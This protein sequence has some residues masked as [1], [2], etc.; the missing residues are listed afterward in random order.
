MVKNHCYPPSFTMECAWLS[1]TLA[2][3]S[4]L[5]VSPKSM[6]SLIF[7][8]K[9]CHFPRNHGQFWANFKFASSSSA[10][11]EYF[12]TAYR[13][14]RCFSATYSSLGN[15]ENTEI[16]FFVTIFCWFADLKWLQNFTRNSALNI[17]L[18]YDAFYLGSLLFKVWSWNFTKINLKFPFLLSVNR[19]FMWDLENPF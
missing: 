18:M 11:L 12:S 5:Q 4:I 7:P 17:T 6:I 10:R 3:H 19:D 16:I 2:A 14:L 9:A 8:R 1:I 13:I 15:L